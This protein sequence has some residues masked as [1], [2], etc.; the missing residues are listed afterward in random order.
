[1]TMVSN[2]AIEADVLAGH[3]RSW[4]NEALAKKRSEIVE[5]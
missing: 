4:A 1:M 2:F 5:L 3:D